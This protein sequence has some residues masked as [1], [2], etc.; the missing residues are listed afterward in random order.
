MTDYNLPGNWHDLTAE[1]KN[2]WYH[3]ERARRQVLRQETPYITAMLSH[4]ERHQRR[5]SA[6]D[7]TVMVRQYR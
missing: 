6:R 3:Q 1:Q 4:L 2:E 7:E 5:A